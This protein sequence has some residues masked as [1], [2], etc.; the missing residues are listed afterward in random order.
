MKR[1]L[2]PLAL[3]SLAL[4]A[5]SPAAPASPSGPTTPSLNATCNDLSFYLDPALASSI[6]CTTIPADATSME[7]HPEFTR[8]TLQGYPLAGTF[9]E[10][11]IDVYPIADY[12]ALLPAAVPGLVADLAGL[13]GGGSA[14][15]FASSFGM[16]LPF[17]PVFNA[18]Q[19]FFAQY[20]AVSFAS[21]DGI[22][23]LTE[24]AQY[25]VPVNNTD[26]F[27]TYQG[28]TTDGQSWVSV[29]MPIN[30]AALPADADA[31]LGAQTWEQFSIGYEPYI[32][33]AVG[34]LDAAASTDFTPTIDALDAL[35]ASITIT[36]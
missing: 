30:L 26:L 28:V 10:A 2:A 31:G 33:T 16:P 11:R 4:C 8:V 17:L 5:C 7:P 25:T 32:L 3:L 23:F 27:Y 21:G 6:T 9:F 1:S 14:P 35:V 18:G 29:I 15:V 22:R 20:Q 34:L 24:F 13:T 12:T 19:A 36:P